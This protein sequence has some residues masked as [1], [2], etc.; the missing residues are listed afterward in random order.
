[1]ARTTPIAIAASPALVEDSGAASPVAASMT[2][3]VRV[4][5]A[6]LRLPFDAA[7]AQYA[8]A[9]QVGLVACSLLASRDFEYALSTLERSILGP[10][11]RRR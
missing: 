5:L 2:A 6:A 1:V 11:A 4:G 3:H 7:R 10:L 9:V 8:R